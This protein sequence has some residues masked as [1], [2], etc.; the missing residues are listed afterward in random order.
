MPQP[1]SKPIFYDPKN[2]RWRWFKGITRVLGVLVTLVFCV[3]IASILT[4][5]ILPNLALAPLKPLIGQSHAFAPTLLPTVPPTTFP[6]QDIQTRVA[7]QAKVETRH[8]ELFGTREPVRALKRFHVSSK[9]PAVLVAPGLSLPGISS[10]T[11]V[12]GAPTPTPAPVPTFSPVPPASPNNTQVIGFYV[13]WDDNSFTSL[14]QNISHIDELIPEWLHLTGANGTIAP[15]DLIKQKEATDFIHLARPNL[16]IVPLI[17]NYNNTTQSWEGDMLGQMLADPAARAHTISSILEYV[18]NNHFA[19]ISVDFENIPAG[20]GPNLTAFM[21]ELYSQFHPLHLEVSISVPVDDSSY[22]YVGLAQNSDYL[23]LMPYDEHWDGSDPG[24]IASQQWFMDALAARFA[25]VDPSKYVV[26][27]GNYGY[28]WPG[29]GQASEVSFQQA[30]QTAQNFNATIRFDPVSLNSYFDYTDDTGLLHHLWYLDAMSAFNEVAATHQYKVHG[31]ALW[32]M[33]SEDPSTW[34]VL[35]NRAHLDSVVSNALSDLQYGYDIV[36]L[37]TGEI[38]KVTATPKDG[39]RAI[40]FDGSTNLITGEQFLS[41][42]SPYIIDRWGGDNPDKI[43]LT[44]DDG[45][46][47]HW[48][49]QIL[50]ILKQYHAPATFFIVGTS[51]TLNPGLLQQI[52]NDGNEVGNHTFTHPDISTI[53]QEQLD[54]ELN[55]TQRLLESVVGRR[56]DLFR[57]P[58]AEDVEPGSP[59]QV[60]PLLLTGQLGYYTIGMHIDPKDYLSPG[61]PNIVQAVITQVT[62]GAGN[63]ILLHD[64]GGDRTQTIFA[65][66]IIIQQLRAR[67]Y[68]FVTVSDLMGMSRDQVMPVISPAERFLASFNNI[69]FQATDGLNAFLTTFFM[70]GIALGVLRFMFIGVLAILEKRQA[71]RARYLPGYQPAVSIIVP[72][73]NEVKVIEKTINALLRTTYPG[74]EIIVVDD[75]STDNTYERVIELF[76]SNPKVRAYKK[77]NGGK[78]QAL[79]FGI[80][81]SGAEIN[82]AIDADTLLLPD[83]PEKLV[84]HFSDPRVGAVAGNAKVGNRINILT[85]WQALEYITSQNL[86]RRAFAVSNCITVVPGAIGAWRRQLVLDLGGFNNDTLAEDAELTLRILRSGY[87]IAYEEDAIALTEAPDTVRAFLKQR[88]R[89]MYGTLQAAW[90][91]RD[92]LLRPRYK[93]LGMLAMPNIFVFQIIFPLISPLMDL[94][95]VISILGIILAS[96]NHPVDPTPSGLTNLVFF[97]V[98]FLCLDLFTA[99]FG[100]L[101]ESREDRTLLFWLFLQRYYYRQLMYYVAVQAVLSAVQGRVVG[102]GKLERKATVSV[103]I[104][105]KQ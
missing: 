93:A 77:S 86:D 75:G 100:F 60:R 101:L 21:G 2:R 64:G 36:Y 28:D 104:V 19:G 76:G 26:G 27:I 97:Y 81:R 72:A 90:K 95:A 16:P 54:I 23:L 35:D 18:Q 56:T 79:N 39:Q 33:G 15:D 32:R 68:Q 96:F 74:T 38:L 66:P 71:R 41:Y 62:S 11:T 7:P 55:A 46:D 30:I 8:Q 29:S 24:P 10:P 47:A 42:P 94:M 57:P 4:T 67:G 51:A 80:E 65:L 13:D 25:Q 1:S 87:R 45:P 58:Y 12:A 83:A 59:D 103:P 9:N 17:N 31:L 91:N 82:L 99:L 70:V 48:T 14:K 44:F 37:G 85:K 92:I 73:H 89:W 22:D 34:K 6:P 84:R 63:V 43:A 20:G 49:P 50:D 40:T 61:V 88:F 102:W 98:L 53:P 78:G 3:L 5:P 52:V 105:H 69:G